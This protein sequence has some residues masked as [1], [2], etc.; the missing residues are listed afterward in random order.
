MRNVSIT[1]VAMVLCSAAGCDG[2]GT[3]SGRS[4]SSDSNVA[5]RAAAP[6]LNLEFVARPRDYLCSA[7]ECGVDQWRLAHT[8]EEAR[9]LMRNGFP[10][11]D[12]LA[13]LEASDI[14]QL[15]RL[16]DSG[17]LPARAQLGLRLSQTGEVARGFVELKRA[18]DEGSLYAYHLISEV[19]L[20]AMH[21][22]LS[23]GAF[24]RVAYLLGDQRAADQ[25]LGLN[26]HPVEARVIDRRAAAL[27]QT[28]ANR[29]KPDPR[30]T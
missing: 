30:P 4:P 7:D 14:S 3:I 24:L 28:F 21:D 17:S 19:Q 1:L 8:A 27:L 20:M 10:A 29:Q 2:G 5:T 15:E 25:M 26:I 12:E 11:P 22:R 13:R 6:Q 9:W 23:A 16:A 18:A